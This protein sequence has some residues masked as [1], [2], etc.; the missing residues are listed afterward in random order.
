MAEIECDGNILT[1]TI[2]NKEGEIVVK[3]VIEYAMPEVKLI[4]QEGWLDCPHSRCGG[5]IKPHQITGVHRA[6]KGW[7]MDMNF[8][9]N[10]C[11]HYEIHGFPIR[12]E[13]VENV[14]KFAGK[15]V[16][17]WSSDV[18]LTEKDKKLI[19]ERLKMLGYWTFFVI[20]ILIGW[21]VI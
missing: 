6:Y 16:D 17:W 15:W 8:K 11:N 4:E 21:K 20:P 19:I 18:N 12:E 7:A 14:R 13:I 5:E 9:C 1:I 2:R 3:W 10:R